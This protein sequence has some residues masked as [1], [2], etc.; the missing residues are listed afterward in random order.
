MK[1]IIK[2]LSSITL[3]LLAFAS[4]QKDISKDGGYKAPAVR[5]YAPVTNAT[6]TQK[7]GATVTLE[8]VN[9]DNVAAVIMG[10]VEAQVTSVEFGK[11]TFIIPLS[12]EFTQ[13]AITVTQIVVKSTMDQGDSFSWKKDYHIFVDPYEAIVTSC[14]PLAGTI[15]DE[16]TLAGY[17]FDKISA[18]KLGETVIASTSFVS[19]TKEQIKF[20]IPDAAYTPGNNVLKL[21]FAWTDDKG[22]SKEGEFGSDFTVKI[23]SVATMT[24]VEGTPALG[25]MLIFTGTNMDIYD[26]VYVGQYKASISKTATELKVTIP[27]KDYAAVLKAAANKSRAALTAVVDIVG[28]Y[29]TPAKTVVLKKDLTIDT[30]P[31]A[32]VEPTFT[33]VIPADG[34]DVAPYR[35]YLKKEVKVVGTGLNNIKKITVGDLEATI[36]EGAMPDELT[37]VMPEAFTFTTATD[38]S[39]KAF[40]SDAGVEVEMVAAAKVYPFYYWKNVTMSTASNSTKSYNHGFANLNAFFIPDQGVLMTTDEMAKGEFDQYLNATDKSGS[41]NNVLSKTVVDKEEKYK[42]VAPY[43]MATT[44]GSHKLAF[45]GPASGS[46]GNVK[47][48]FKADKGALPASGT[49]LIGFKVLSAAEDADKAFVEAAKGGTLESV[50]AAN[51]APT[52]STPYLSHTTSI[53]GTAAFTQGDVIVV[54]WVGYEKGA[55]SGAVAGDFY[56]TGVIVFKTAT[57]FDFNSTTNPNGLT[58]ENNV[59]VDGAAMTIRNQELTFDV[60]WPYSFRTK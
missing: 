5:L 43:F 13:N 25:D 52:S 22:V 17:N 55:V 53:S 15:G 48:H 23:P 51:Y 46:S 40:Y 41:V 1:N 27:A 30:T 6:V 24:P 49:P 7:P 11:L 32:V 12:P 10:G 54:G 26:E 39:I 8:G 59:T 42:A 4:C 44:N 35:F 20:A 45:V 29:G 56:K 37:F 2:Y 21:K 58:P 34:G 38:Q 3:C 19:A 50:Y 60:Y 18:L 36:K 28:H 14:T 47:S 9:L 57:N 33:S 16:I 31:P